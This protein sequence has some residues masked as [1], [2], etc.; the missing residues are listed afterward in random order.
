MSSTSFFSQ[1]VREKETHL[2]RTFAT[3]FNTSA[4]FRHQILR[5]LF[6]TCGIKG[7][8][9]DA[10]WQCAT[11]VQTPTAG[12]GRLDLRFGGESSDRSAKTPVFVI[13]NK[14]EAKLTLKQLRKYRR[15][16]VKYLVAVT[17]YAPDVPE[18][19]MNREGVFALRWQDVH[20]YLSSQLPAARPVDRFLVRSFL[21]YL[22]DLKM[23][24]PEQL[25]VT[26]LN[27]LRRALNVAVSERRYKGLDPKGAFATADVC[28]Q[29]LEELRR[30]LVEKFPELGTLQALGSDVLCLARRQRRAGQERTPRICVADSGTTLV[31]AVLRMRLL[32][33]TVS[34]RADC[35]GGVARKKRQTTQGNDVQAIEVQ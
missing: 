27:Q 10:V 1:L 18:R 22:E 24:Y 33:S 31:R 35:V 12:G 17:K 26:D 23:A 13:E 20:R 6:D 25:K 8:V 3:C 5:L 7:R 2:S 30:Q 21:S 14:V 19:Q 15:H 28:L 9:V 32:F 4:V 11:E 29:F 16:D 34:P